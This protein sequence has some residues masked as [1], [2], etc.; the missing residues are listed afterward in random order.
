[1]ELPDIIAMAAQLGGPRKKSAERRYPG[2]L[3]SLNREAARDL[4]D[5][6][7][8]QTRIQRKT[9]KPFFIDKMPS[10]FLHV[11]LICLILPNAKIIDARRHPMACCFSGFKQQFAEGHRYSYSL[12]EIGRFYRDYVEYMEHFDRVL[13]G[14]VHRV[15]YEQM[16]E[17][18]E[19][20]TRRLFA[21]CG[22]AFESACLRFH[23]NARPVRTASSQQVRKPL[24]RE[25]LDHWR[26]YEPWLEPLKR[27]LG[28]VLEDTAVR[29]EYRGLL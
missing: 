29:K 22:L 21:H 28:E 12:E 14:R 6:Y 4:G 1:M 17:D 25:A 16:V 23:E 20:V 27:A 11:G 5:R 19:G 2:V 10:N 13:P 8:A 3:A 15:A 9:S 24:Y 7:L 26:H 18:P